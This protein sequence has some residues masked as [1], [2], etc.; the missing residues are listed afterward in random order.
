MTPNAPMKLSFDAKKIAK[1]GGNIAIGFGGFTAGHLAFNKVVPQ[2]LRTGV[3]AIIITLLMFAVGAFVATQTQNEK[4]QAAASGFGIY[5]F[6]K[7]LNT[8]STFSPAVSGLDGFSFA[9]PEGFTKALKS[10][11]PNLGE[12]DP[13]FYDMGELKI[14]EAGTDIAAV[15]TEYEIIQGLHGGEDLIL[16]EMGAIKSNFIQKLPTNSQIQPNRSGPAGSGRYGNGT[17]TFNMNG[18]S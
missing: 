4:V 16:P 5:G 8:V 14:F 13:L 1:Q 3:K 18:M 12:A 15:D 17:F 2:T 6:T 9:L 11:V 7:C 10:F